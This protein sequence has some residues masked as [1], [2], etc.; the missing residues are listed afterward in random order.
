[1]SNPHTFENDIHSPF[2]AV[3]GTASNRARS[4]SL[5]FHLP[6]IA[7]FL[8]GHEFGILAKFDYT[9]WNI[10]YVLFPLLL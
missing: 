1:M 8:T 7:N 5:V 10:E 2:Y 6:T 3:Y 9:F 4:A